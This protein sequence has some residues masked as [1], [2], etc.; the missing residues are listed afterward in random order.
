MLLR[1]AAFRLPKR[2]AFVVAT[3]S[4]AAVFASAGTPIPLYGLLRADDGYGDSDFAYAS[5]G[6]FVAAVASLLILGRL[7]NHVG[8][9]PLA[10]TALAA[11]AVGA[12]LLP[13]AHDPWIFIAARILQGL[14]AGVAP[15]TI[16]AYVIDT[17]P[18]KPRWLPALITASTPMLGIPLGA[19]TSGIIVE[20]TAQ[21][22]WIAAGVLV[23]VLVALMALVALSPETMSR[24]AGAWRSLRPRLHVPAGAGRVLLA[25][26]TA[27]IATWS[28]GGFY[29]AFAPT[30]ASQ[31]LG[32]DDALVAGIVFS[33][34]MVL[35]PVGGPLAARLS[36][37]V[38]VRAGM[39]LFLV[40][41][42]SLVLALHQ[43]AIVPF[44]VAS[45]TVGIA[46]GVAGTSA[47]RAL[48]GGL[49]PHERAGLLATVY[50]MSYGGTAVPGLISGQLA[51]HVEP[52]VLLL[53]YAALGTLAAVT[54]MIAISP[55]RPAEPALGVAATEV[56]AEPLSR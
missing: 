43:G 7:S 38:G 22:R 37:T 33:S 12:A 21:P 56:P 19:I 39:T 44:L 23:A 6:Y 10:L 45:L 4:F 27:A 48:V 30:I 13:V 29:Q 16:G 9:K 53:G 46:Q 24:T 31:Y 55:R 51:P 25:A 36:P 20:T 26:G 28:L 1:G 5:V 15:S 3:A 35:N 14:A 32:T 34:M 50:L 47:M 18:Q 11:T 8:R 2:A 52:I 17:A 40:A 41:L 49:A 54:A 42:A